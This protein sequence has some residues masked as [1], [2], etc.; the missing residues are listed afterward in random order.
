M[1]EIKF[2]T[3]EKRQL[4][5]DML[6]KSTDPRAKKYISRLKRE[7]EYFTAKIKVHQ[8]ECSDMIE[9]FKLKKMDCDSDWRPDA[10]EFKNAKDKNL[11]YY[12]P[13]L[14]W[15]KSTKKVVDEEGLAYGEDKEFDGL[16]EQLNTLLDLCL[17]IIHRY[18][19]VGRTEFYNDE[20]DEWHFKHMKDVAML[21]GEH[22]F[23][24]CEEWLLKIGDY[25]VN[26]QELS[27][28]GTISMI[29]VVNDLE[30]FGAGFGYS[31]EETQ[32]KVILV[33]I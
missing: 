10:K 22:Y 28:Q 9:K 30:K 13:A 15:L 12:R 1:D 4:F 24:P 8:E 23:F 2:W 6:E 21:S 32:E 5:V 31:L 17:G 19:D 3:N 29:S 33:E 16:K 26:Y 11:S 27:G 25:Y 14:E 20:V 18:E 7:I